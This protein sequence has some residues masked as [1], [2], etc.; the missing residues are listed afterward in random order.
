[1]YKRQ[2]ETVAALS[3]HPN[4][5]AVKEAN[6]N[7]SSAAQVAALCDIDIYS[8][9]DDQIVPCLLYTSFVCIDDF[10]ITSVKPPYPDSRLA[11]Y[12]DEQSI[13]TV[14]YTHLDVYKRQG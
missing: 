8:G 1:M 14:S 10:P 6:G 4:I 7:I 13:Q 9:N 12:T 3:K 5:V 11:T 2:P